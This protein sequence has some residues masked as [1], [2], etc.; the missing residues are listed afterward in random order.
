MQKKNKSCQKG[1]WLNDCNNCI[2]FVLYYCRQMLKGQLTNIENSEKFRLK[3]ISMMPHVITCVMCT[4]IIK[5]TLQHYATNILSEW[6]SPL[7]ICISPSNSR[8]LNFSPRSGELVGQLFPSPLL[9]LKLKINI[10]SRYRCASYFTNY[11]TRIATEVPV[12]EV[13]C[14]SAFA[15]FSGVGVTLPL[16]HSLSPVKLNLLSFS[17]WLLSAGHL[18]VL[19]FVSSAVTS[20]ASDIPCLLKCIRR[21]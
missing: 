19:V 18:F 14:P 4:G 20:R 5:Y 6:I 7:H 13:I 21:I 15:S 8:S 9:L 12:K 17:I 16:S 3:Y 1:I 11:V 10:P 2:R